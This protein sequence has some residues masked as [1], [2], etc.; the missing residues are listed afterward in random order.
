MKHIILMSFFIFSVKTSA[1][2]IEGIAR[3]ENG[4]FAYRELQKITRDKS[5]DIEKIETTFFTEEGRPFASINSDFRKNKYIPD[6]IF[7]DQRFDE[8]TT[9]TVIDGNIE[10]KFFKK[11]NLNKTSSLKLDGLM[12]T[13][14]G[15]QNLIRDQ[16][17]I[18]ENKSKTVHFVVTPRADYF[19]F[20]VSEAP[21]AKDSERLITIEPENFLLRMFVSKIY[22]SYSDLGKNLRRFQGISNINSNKNENQVVDIAYKVIQEEI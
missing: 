15:F 5:G 16:I 19:R 20:K 11:N 14:Q 6:T 21:P 18:G 13:D 10:F 12:V 8:T 2:T 22:L 1:E 3:L 17:L 4:E 9:T 7:S